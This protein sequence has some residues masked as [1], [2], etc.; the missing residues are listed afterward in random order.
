MS[1]EPHKP[2]RILIVD[3][4]RDTCEALKDRLETFG[5]EIV[6]CTDGASALAIIRL[7]S[8]R[9]PFHLVLLDLNM[10]GVDGMAVLHKL[11]C[12]DTSIPVII[13]SATARREALLDAVRAGANDSLEKPILYEELRKKCQRAIGEGE[14]R[15]SSSS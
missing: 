5:Y 12:P 11:R 3:D 15:R 1:S 2:H 9:S 14:R 7:E 8:A 6:T 13:M 10:P 4:D